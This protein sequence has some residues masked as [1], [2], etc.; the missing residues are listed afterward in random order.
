M[1]LSPAHLARRS[2]W[3]PV[4]LAAAMATPAFAAT[5]PL[6][7]PGTVIVDHSLPKTQVAAQLLAARRYGTFWNNGA[8]AL[9]RAALAPDFKDSTL[10]PGRAQGIAGPLAASKMMHAAVPDLRCE[11]KQMM[12]VGDR[13]VSHL[14]F[15]GHFS[16]Q[17][18]G[19]QGKGQPIDFIATDIYR[20]VD[21]R[22]AENWHLEDNLTFMQQVDLVAK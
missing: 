8:E 5:D 11:I 14:R 20:I 10:P 6:V 1:S 4:F 3:L 21:G 16:G 22:I 2:F 15:T 19:V 12:V 7:Q 9:A 17:L 18:K 13:V